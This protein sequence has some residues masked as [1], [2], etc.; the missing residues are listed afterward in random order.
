MI[1]LGCLQAAE[2]V[3]VFMGHR[4]KPAGVAAM[5]AGTLVVVILVVAIIIYIYCRFC[6]KASDTG[7]RPQRIGREH[8]PA[9]G[10]AHEMTR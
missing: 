9:A 7:G 3:I 2:L 10:E 1:I 6:K 8:L 4:S 5:G